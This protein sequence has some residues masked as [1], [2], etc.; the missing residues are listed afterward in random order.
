VAPDI[1]LAMW[2]LRHRD[3]L[4]QGVMEIAGS[5]QPEGTI[6]DASCVSDV[7]YGTWLYP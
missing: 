4:V 1:P 7:V 6:S 2:A 5:V 3:V